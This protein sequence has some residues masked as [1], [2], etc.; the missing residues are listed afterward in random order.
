MNIEYISEGI[1]RLITLDIGGRGIIYKLYE[2]A[3]DLVKK[4]LTL[5]AAEKI[6]ERVGYGD[7]IIIATGF[8]ILPNAIQETDG[9]LG[10][11]T[12]ARALKMAYGAKPIILIE[13]VSINI[14]KASLDALN[15]KTTVDEEAF[16]RDS[17]YILLKSFPYESDEADEEAEKLMDRYNPSLLI[18]IEKVGMNEVG[19]Y[20]TMK[21]YNVTQYH[22][23]IEPLIDKMRSINALTIGIGDGG[24]E[25]GMGN[26]I[27]TV[28]KY[29]PYS[30]ECQC[31]C[32][33]GIAAVSKVDILITAA[34][35]NWG[36]Y[37]LEA[38]IALFKG[39]K[40]ALHTENDEERMLHNIVDAGSVDG[41][42]GKPVLSVDGIPL[43][44]H[45]SI[46]KILRGF[47][48]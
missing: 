46:I 27:D 21:G 18:S 12:L 26:I 38:L 3:R 34:V 7:Y 15:L 22:S 1:D 2:A 45:K 13:D 24:N 9:P 31:H 25:V 39:D 43:D 37:G 48:R 29:V 30:T 36:G 17:D 10:A 47:L 28:K 41:V 33:R 6:D 8:R 16:T 42:L 40:E 35:S 23:K 4:P 19:E 32:R 20:H 11:S 44:I 14:M 5:V